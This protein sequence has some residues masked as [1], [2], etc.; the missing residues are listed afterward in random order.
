[1]SF[2]GVQGMITTLKNNRIQK[3][4]RKTLYDRDNV[5]SK[6]TYGEMDDHKQMKSHEFA[7]FQKE[8]FIKRAK[9]RKNDIILKTVVVL[10]T[11]MLVLL[12]LY[13]WNTY[14]SDVLVSPE[15]DK[16]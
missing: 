11:L 6:G 1:M 14:D 12:F 7:T 15:F 5:F 13:I 16:F 4:E 9:E 10:I 2:G 3:G 8:Q